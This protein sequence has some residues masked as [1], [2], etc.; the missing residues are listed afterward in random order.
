MA[1][2]NCRTEITASS[3]LPQVKMP[4]SAVIFTGPTQA[5]ARRVEEPSK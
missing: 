3:H 4:V 5:R 2:K 1:N